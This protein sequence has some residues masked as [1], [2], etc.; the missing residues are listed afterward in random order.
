[1][2]VTLSTGTTHF[3]VPG[4][5][6]VLTPGETNFAAGTKT[7]VLT[8]TTGSFTYN[9]AGANVASTVVEEYQ[10]STGVQMLVTLPA[11]VTTSHFI[12]LYR[13]EMSATAD[14]E[15]SDELY[16]QYEST[17]AALDISNGYI[18]LPYD[19][20]PESFLGDALYTNSNDG[21]GISQAN[22]PPPVALDLCQWDGCT[23]YANYLPRQ[24]LA[25]NIL[26]VG[27]TAGVQDGDTI[28]IG[29]TALTFKTV[30]TLTSHVQ[31]TSN[32]TPALNIETTARQLIQQVNEVL[33]G[34][35]TCWGF[36]ASGSNDA[37]GHLLFEGKTPSTAAFT[38]SV[39]RATAF[40]PSLP[41]TSTNS[42][43]PNGLMF[44]KPGQP[45]AVPLLN[46]VLV[47]SK[48]SRILRAVPLKSS[49]LVFKELDG[50]WQVTGTN[51]RYSVERIG[52][53]RLRGL[54]TVQVFSDRVWALTDQ[55][56]TAISEGA[57][58]VSVVSFGI[59]AEIASSAATLVLPNTLTMAHAVA[60][61]QDRRYVL[62][63]PTYA[64]SYQPYYAFSYSSATKAFTRWSVPAFCS[65]I[66]PV[67]GALC[68]GPDSNTVWTERK[69][70]DTT[71]YADVSG[72]VTITAVDATG[73]VL[74]LNSLANVGVGYVLENPSF[75]AIKAVIQSVNNATSQVTI[76]AAHKTGGYA[77]FTAGATTYYTPYQCTVRWLPYTGGQPANAKMV[78]NLCL[79][80]GRSHLFNGTA[81]FASELLNAEAQ[82]PLTFDG[83][84]IANGQLYG[85]LG[86]IAPTDS[87]ARTR[88]IYPLPQEHAAA[89]QLNVG[90]TS[91]EAYGYWQLHGWV[92]DVN[93][94]S[95]SSWRQG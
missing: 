31:I 86:G 85:T 91:N 38:V 43:Q 74:T 78:N 60:Y 49:L 41:R 9:E 71:D 23:W 87:I 16:L 5:T 89:A 35:F 2:T 25:I 95:D 90:F 24:R 36:Y 14:V 21:E 76:S 20:T 69:A 59:D 6:V 77:A 51:G 83:W 27:A 62:W 50:V 72:A 52:V 84:A 33:P 68:I 79:L 64:F 61:E 29:G 45:E 70:L 58:G 47:G 54:E 88:A 94:E 13:S 28:T 63:T 12:Q 19:R 44:S 81:L 42:A 30:A 73:L 82:V 56:I 37:P 3:L 32:L 15:P 55:G 53:A 26:G 92:L 93:P 18:Q 75:T 4:D 39:S 22:T 8:P 80:F 67:T 46:Q 1:V 34:S 17:I 11:N 66:N 7:V 48:S 65:A 57:S 40:S 10:A